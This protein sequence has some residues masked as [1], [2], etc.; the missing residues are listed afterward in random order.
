[1]DYFDSSPSLYNESYTNLT[2][3]DD[4]GVLPT[5]V[6]ITIAMVY[7]VVCIVGLLGNSLVMYVIIR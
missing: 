6:K 4:V 5:G 1:M 2:D 7:M 3:F